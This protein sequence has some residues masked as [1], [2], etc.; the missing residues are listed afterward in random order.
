MKRD[1]ALKNMIK[2][3]ERAEEAAQQYPHV[4][5]ADRSRASLAAFMADTWAHV[6]EQLEEYPL[7]T[8]QIDDRYLPGDGPPL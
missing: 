5:S 3:V 7:Y 4:S 8:V 6:A 1:E 2:W